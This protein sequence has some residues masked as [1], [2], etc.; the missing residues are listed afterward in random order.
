MHTC[1]PACTNTQLSLYGASLKAV[2]YIY[3]LLSYPLLAKKAMPL[4]E[5]KPSGPL[6]NSTFSRTETV[7][8]ATNG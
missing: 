6:Q 1:T 3:T 7:V 2:G 8:L 5:A 4:T